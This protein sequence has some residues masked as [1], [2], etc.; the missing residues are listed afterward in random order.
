M[1]KSGIKFPANF[2]AF[3]RKVVAFDKSGV[4]W[5]VDPNDGTISLAVIIPPNDPKQK[6]S[7]VVKK[8]KKDKR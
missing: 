8:T 4:P 3:D 1:A 2:V 6:Q 5:V 7:A